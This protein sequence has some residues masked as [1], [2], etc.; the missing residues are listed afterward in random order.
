LPGLVRG[1]SRAVNGTLPPGCGHPRRAFGLA[2]E[3]ADGLL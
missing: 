2:D 1:P 3:A